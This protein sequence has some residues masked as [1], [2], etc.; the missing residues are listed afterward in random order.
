MEK[1][2]MAQFS[3]NHLISDNPFLLKKISSVEPGDQVHITGMLAEYSHSNGRFKRGTS[4]VRTDTG[5][6]ACE[7]I[8]VEEFEILQRNNVFW[9]WLRDLTFWAMPLSAIA[10]IWF[11]FRAPISENHFSDNANDG[12]DLNPLI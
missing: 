5:N 11:Y 9:R 4:T 10:C 3:N 12:P 6:G 8:F 1:I 7:T 2:H